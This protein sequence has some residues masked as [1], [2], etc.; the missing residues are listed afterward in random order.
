MRITSDWPIREVPGLSEA[1][2][3]VPVTSLCL[4][5][6]GNGSG[7]VRGDPV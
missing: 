6:V 4:E 1:G 2:V 5:D 3:R 7:A